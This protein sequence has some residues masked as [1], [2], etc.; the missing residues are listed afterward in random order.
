[1]D[2]EGAEF[3][4]I[5]C[6]ANSPQVRLVDKLFMEVHDPS[7]GLVGN[8]EQEFRRAQ[9][10]LRRQGVAIPAYNSPTLLQTFSQTGIAGR[11]GGLWGGRWGGLWKG[12]WG[13]LWR[14]LWGGRRAKRSI[15]CFINRLPSQR[16]AQ[17]SLRCPKETARVG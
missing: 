11:R 10:S 1:M 6:L 2:I 3:D 15:L 13:G 4:I 14:G 9:A 12:L 7:W 5:P 16:K 8:S 17:F